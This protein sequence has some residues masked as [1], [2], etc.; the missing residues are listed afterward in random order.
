[1]AQPRLPTEFAPAE[2]I[3]KDAVQSQS[4][5]FLDS[6]L[7]CQLL[8]S[9]PDIL[10]VLNKQRQ[11]VFANRALYDLLG[12]KETDTDKVLGRRQGEVLSC[13][14][15]FESEGGCGTT[16]FCSACGAMRAILSSHKMTEDVQECRITQDQSGEA[17]D[18]RVWARPIKLEGEL[19]TAFSVVDIRH[20][21]RRQAL[22]RI[23]FHDVLNTAGGLKGSVELLRD[24]SVEEFEEFRDMISH[25]L[26]ELIEEI[27]AQRELT[28][29]ERDELTL[30]PVSVKT[31]AFLHEVADLYAN[32]E[33][34]SGRRIRVDPD[35]W[36]GVFSTDRT[37]LRRIVGNMT[38]NALE[39]SKPGETV[40][41]GCEQAESGIAFWV[42]NPGVMPPDVQLQIFQRSFSTKGAGRG[43]GTYSIKLLTERYLRGSVSFTSLPEQGT[44]FRARCPDLKPGGGSAASGADESPVNA[45]HDLR[46]LLAED[47]PVNQRLVV[48]LL[49]KQGHAVV[50]VGDGRAAVDAIEEQPFDVALMDVE[51]PEMNGFE[52]TA[53]IRKR[54]GE[55]GAHIPIVALTAHA[56]AG[57]QARCLAAGMDGYVAKPI[58]WE[59]IFRVIDSLVT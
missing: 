24:A 48:R 37:L 45:R 26:D 51:M 10:L 41:L 23:F 1:M 25:L 59:E 2:R 14:H 52:A 6:P 55:T 58:Q 3:P 9:V 54:E 8:S 32:H 15:A 7:A 50:A 40:S 56:T 30:S 21:K 27:K 39:A 13:V 35:A 53:A 22:E 17:L 38:K 18:L 36:D 44:T 43:L 5:L 47:N 33:V 20:E 28:A 34:A 12:L 49:E 29:A 4:Q 31:A 19:F 11:I 46:I 42:H 16:K 57:D